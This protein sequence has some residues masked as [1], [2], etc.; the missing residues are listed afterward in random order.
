MAS[1]EKEN[2]CENK[3]NEENDERIENLLN[4]LMILKFKKKMCKDLRKAGVRDT[5]SLKKKLNNIYF[6][7]LKMYCQLNKYKFDNDLIKIEMKI[8]LE[9]LHAEMKKCTFG[10]KL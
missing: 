1:E 3:E 5:Y 8:K 2:N 4:E 10:V 6:R 7:K 9:E